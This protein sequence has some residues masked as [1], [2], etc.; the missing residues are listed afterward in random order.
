LQDQLA[1][2]G[3]HVHKVL[4]EHGRISDLEL[5]H[6]EREAGNHAVHDLLRL[7]GIDQSNCIDFT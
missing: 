7:A 4:G 1:K 3:R 6:L 5:L 2:V